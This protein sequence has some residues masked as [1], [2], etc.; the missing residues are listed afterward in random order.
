LHFL[1]YI[2]LDELYI[3]VILLIDSVIH[4]KEGY[5]VAKQLEKPDWV[6]NGTKTKGLVSRVLVLWELQRMGKLDMTH[7][8]KTELAKF[9]GVTRM[10]LDRTLA[11]VVEVQPEVERLLRRADADYVVKPATAEEIARQRFDQ[12]SEPGAWLDDTQYNEVLQLAGMPPEDF[13]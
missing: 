6:E 9:F 5:K 11:M 12:R 2:E 3:T 13:R 10:T 1:P 4:L 8:A 7:G